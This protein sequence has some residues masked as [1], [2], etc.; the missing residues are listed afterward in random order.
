MLASQ[1]PHERDSFITFEEEPHIY[2]VH[3]DSS[4]TSVTTWNHRHFDDFNG[5]EVANNILRGKKM[6]DPNY[7]YYGM[8]KQQILDMWKKS[9]IEASI[10][11]TKLHYDIECFYNQIESKNDSIEFD[12][13]LKFSHDFSNL[14]PYRTEWMVYYEELKLAGSIDMVYINDDGNLLIYDWKRCK[15]IENDKGSFTTYSKTKC[16]SH[17]PNTNFWH[18]ALQLNMY[19]TILEHKYDKKVV[20]LFL[21]RL[22]PDNAYKSYERIEIPFLDKEM[23]DLI[24]H[25][26]QEICMT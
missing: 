15:E 18:Y 10:A 22:H 12:Y 8:T 9:A 24:A 2:T 16:I 17:L 13:F 11:G 25:R 23:T 26:K 21:I 5:E 1:N 4:Y 19:K 3:G 7:A 14:K 6:S 20:G